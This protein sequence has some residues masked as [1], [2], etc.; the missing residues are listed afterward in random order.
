MANVEIN[1]EQA[2]LI[3]VGIACSEAYLSVKG[4]SFDLPTL[5]NAINLEDSILS[6]FP[7]LVKLRS[8][9][10]FKD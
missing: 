6:K 4:K 10:S 3:L 7:N 1:G 5:R 8:K 9:R 2:G